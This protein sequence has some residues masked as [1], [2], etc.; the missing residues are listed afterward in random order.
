[1]CLLTPFPIFLKRIFKDIS[2]GKDASIGL[3]TRCDFSAL[4]Y[5]LFFFFNFNFL[6]WY[7]TLK[8]GDVHEKF[9]F[10]ERRKEL[11]PLRN[12]Q[13]HFETIVPNFLLDECE[14]QGKCS[15]V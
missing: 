6:R 9:S 8:C 15:V 11:K 12:C 13:N 5:N 1:M 10:L 2:A 7:G 4:N 3:C 14:T